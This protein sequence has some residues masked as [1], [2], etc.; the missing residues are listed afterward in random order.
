M[1][2]LSGAINETIEHTNRRSWLLLVKQGYK[3]LFVCVATRHSYAWYRSEV[4]V[5]LHKGPC[6]NVGTAEVK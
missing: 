6:L 3:Y 2:V 4:E 1:W 5:V